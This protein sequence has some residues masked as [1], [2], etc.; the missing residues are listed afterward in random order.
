[1][2]YKEKREKAVLSE[3]EVQNYLDNQNHQI[4]YNKN[5]V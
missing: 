5:F 3:E 1:M 4:Y 2:S